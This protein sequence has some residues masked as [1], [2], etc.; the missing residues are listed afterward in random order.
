MLK[1]GPITSRNN[2]YCIEMQWHVYSITDRASSI[3]IKLFIGPKQIFKP[4]S[5]IQN[6]YLKSQKNVFRESQTQALCLEVNYLIDVLQTPFTCQ[7]QFYLILN[8]ISNLRKDKNY[9]NYVCPEL[10]PKI[11]FAKSR[12]PSR[13]L[14]KQLLSPPNYSIDALNGYTITYLWPHGCCGPKRLLGLFCRQARPGRISL[15]SVAA[16]L[17][18][19]CG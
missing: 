19:L 18:S 10:K 4:V 16:S 14:G 9:V 7:R 13:L 8:L 11:V 5:Y 6:K 3:I 2:Q 15:L 17:V 12:T 1:H